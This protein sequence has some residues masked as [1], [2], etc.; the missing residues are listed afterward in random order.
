MHAMH[1]H[2]VGGIP[3]ESLLGHLVRD[4][5]LA[6]AG[7]GLYFVLDLIKYIRNSLPMDV[8]D[9]LAESRR[10]DIL[11]WLGQGERAAGDIAEHFSMSAPAT[12]QHLRVLRESGLVRARP[13]AQRRIYR[14]DPRGF[15]AVR[16]WIDRVRDDWNRSLD[17]LQEALEDEAA[18]NDATSASPETG[19]Q[20]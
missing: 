6:N 17:R 20:T 1:M 10:R 5:G 3:P 9:A 2:L 11:D 8:F 19:D 16:N 15:E 14:L 4:G 18:R 7:S 13:E 12:S